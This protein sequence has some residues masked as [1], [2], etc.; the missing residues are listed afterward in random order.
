MLPGRTVT[1]VTLVAAAIACGA[2]VAVAQEKNWHKIGT[3]DCT[4]GPSI[5]LVY[6][7]RQ[8]ARCNFLDLTGAKKKN[9]IGRASRPGLN[10]GI[11]PGS[12]LFWTVFAQS[13]SDSGQETLAGSY[14]GRCSDM[15]ASGKSLSGPEQSLCLQ[16]HPAKMQRRRNLAPEITKL[17]LE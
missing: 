12:K 17:R 16:A 6:G 2:T 14:E 9:Y 7:D 15:S 13:S 11:A 1:A 4:M 10:K 8:Q 3:L 5:G